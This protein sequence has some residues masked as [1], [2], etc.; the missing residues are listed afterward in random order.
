[1]MTDKKRF[2][3]RNILLK[4]QKAK[5]LGNKQIIR[6]NKQIIIP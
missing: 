2:K 4:K 5:E 6:I 1:M 3:K